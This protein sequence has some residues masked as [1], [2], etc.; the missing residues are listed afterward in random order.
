ME[1]KPMSQSI[2]RG[3]YASFWIILLM[4]GILVIDIWTPLGFGVWEL[5]AVPLWLAFRISKSTP[6]LI[7]LLAGMGALFRVLEIGISRPGGILLY[8]WFNRSLWAAVLCATAAVLTTA[9]KN[10]TAVRES[11]ERLRASEERYRLLRSEE[12]RVGK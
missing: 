11:E 8:A 7:W 5:Y 1:G 9:R 12:R 6:R 10:E 4:A 3:N 2:V